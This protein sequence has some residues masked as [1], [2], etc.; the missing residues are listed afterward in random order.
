MSTWFDVP[1]ALDWLRVPAALLLSAAVVW[2]SLHYAR[3]R[4]L[5]DLPGRRRSHVKP[6]PRGGG[7]GIVAAAAV[8]FV[9]L[10]FALYPGW[11][12]AGTAI[13]AGMLA[14][15]A[16]G[17][18]DDHHGL[19]I[20]P[21]LAVHTAAALGLALS[22]AE[23]EDAV[24]IAILVLAGV[25]FI[26]L[27]NFMDGIDGL[28]GVQALFV[29]SLLGVLGWL[30]AARYYS[31]GM[32]T[33]AAA[34]L[35]FLPFNFP[36]AR[37]FMGD[38][39]SGALGFLLA[40]SIGMALDNGLLE[41]GEALILVSAFVVDASC[42]LVLRMARGRRWYSAHREHLYQWLVRSGWSHARTV[43][44]YLGWNLFVVAP[45]LALYENSNGHE[46]LLLTFVYAVALVLWWC[47]RRFCLHNILVN[48]AINAA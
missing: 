42:T 43:G 8:L 31:L 47:A 18:V 28:L 37:I 16:V 5:Y 33:L 13:L 35:G 26:N 2:L 30:D 45:A 1:V 14:V 6:T 17:W 41:P 10:A 40:A 38:V 48:K 22:V 7:V 19:G 27:H 23:Y 4:K 24:T 29:F 46:T 11:S 20:M 25:W 9:P 32:F 21:R 34:T 15:A 39:G 36:R 44:W 12:G 3:R